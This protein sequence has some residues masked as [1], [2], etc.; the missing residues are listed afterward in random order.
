MVDV[1]EYI[2][3]SNAIESVHEESAVDK[4]FE[5]WEY[6]RSSSELT[7]DVV[8]GGHERILE[9]RQPEIAGEYRDIQVHIG[10]QMPPPPIA[11]KG[12]MDTLLEWTPADPLEAIHWHI[13]FE[14]IHPFAD[15]NGRIG[16]VLYLWH[17]RTV[18]DS[19]P[20]M[21]RAADRDGYYDLFSA[22]V[23]VSASV[24]D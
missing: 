24:D 10:E 22:T 18:L 19:E 11:V 21:W 6:L 5:A 17:C 1:R 16:R 9:Q 7:Q 2:R 8:R 20:V 15:G 13:A 4:S 12:E 3:E 23:D 14:H